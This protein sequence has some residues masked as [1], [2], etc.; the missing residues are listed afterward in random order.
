MFPTIGEYN[1]TIQNRGEDAFQTLS[2]L[3]FVA[4]TSH[5]IK[6]FLFGA[7]AYAVVFKANQNGKYFAIRCFLTAEQETINRYKT[8]CDYL[9]TINATWIA[10][11][12]FL[13][14]EI[15]VNGNIFPVLKME[16][17]EGVLINQFV[18]ANLTNANTLSLIQKQLVEV[19][20]SLEQN[21]VGH[22]DLQCGNI[23]IQGTSNIFKIK[24]I[25]YDGMF[26]PTITSKK[27][28]EKGRSE[29]Q[30]PN[31]SP[32]YFSS[33]VDRFSFW[34]MLT[35]LEALK[36][37][38]SLWKEI[39]QGGFNTLDNFLFTINDFRNTSESKLFNRLQQINSTSLNFYSEKLKWFCNHDASQ[40]DKPTLFTQNS[41]SFNTKAEDSLPKSTS[42]NTSPEF[43]LTKKI[44]ITSNKS[45][46]FVLNSTS[47][48]V[49]GKTPLEI[50]LED[51]VGKKLLISSGGE[52]QQITVT[53]SDSIF[54]IL[55]TE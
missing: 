49:I 23:I 46:S 15:R 39:M 17:V 44:I 1:Q 11:C 2:N 48:K 6:I 21:K 27:S 10:D 40:I 18:S 13:E 16:W 30:H 19:S 24:L 8:I 32:Y 54:E 37:D 53:E 33:D 20:E 38:T 34:V 31:R 25:D 41:N 47:F 28:I 7:G 50:D 29:F 36:F 14:N 26:V 3:S 45:E 4:A 22:G 55:F 12:Q 43:S 42:N 9:K 35:A 51:C 5:P 52:V